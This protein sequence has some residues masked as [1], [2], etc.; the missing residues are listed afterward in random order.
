MFLEFEKSKLAIKFSE[1]VAVRK[2]QGGIVIISTKNNEYGVEESYEF[3]VEMLEK[4]SRQLR[5]NQRI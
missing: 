4:A 3:V 5:E 2:R 1:I